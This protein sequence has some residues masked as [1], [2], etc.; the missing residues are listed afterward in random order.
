MYPPV[1]PPFQT[2][3]DAHLVRRIDVQSR[4]VTT[5]AG[6]PNSPDLSDGEGTNAHF[7]YPG[8][9]ALNGGATFALVVSVGAAG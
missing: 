1:S 9:I 3:Y 8:G 5:V 6:D 7:N 4:T 2:D